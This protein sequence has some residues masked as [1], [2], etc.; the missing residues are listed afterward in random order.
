MGTTTGKADINGLVAALERQATEISSYAGRVDAVGRGDL[1]RTKEK[2][3][4][5]VSIFESLLHTAEK[6]LDDMSRDERERLRRQIDELA[7]FVLSKSV[8]SNIQFCRLMQSGEALP[9]CA[10]EIFERDARVLERARRRLNQPK[11]ADR[12]RQQDL[13]NIETMVGILRDLIARAPELPV[14]KPQA[15]ADEW[16]QQFV[17]D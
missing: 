6:R 9:L 8:N 13:D 3:R 11:Y 7:M 10:R 12:V 17:F 2:F 5:R 16:Y 4:E 14:F 1:L 15:Y